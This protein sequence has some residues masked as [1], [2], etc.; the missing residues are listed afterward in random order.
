MGTQSDGGGCTGSDEY[1]AQGGYALGGDSGCI[2]DARH[3]AVASLGQAADAHHLLVPPRTRDLIQF[4]VSELVTN[5]LKYAP[6]PILMELRLTARVVDVV[7]RDSDP[8]VPTARLPDPGRIGQ[9][10]LEI[11]KAVTEDLFIEQEPAGEHITARIA[12]SGI[13]ADRSSAVARPG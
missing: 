13:T 12:L 10:C 2:V 3:H 1:L 4:V 8:L 7:V 11:V 5:A 9:H 6:G